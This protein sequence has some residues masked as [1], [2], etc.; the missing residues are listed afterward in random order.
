MGRSSFTTLRRSNSF[1]IQFFSTNYFCFLSGHILCFQP[2]N[3][4]RYR[5]LGRK[6]TGNGKLPKLRT[7]LKK[8]RVPA[9]RCTLCWALTAVYVVAQRQEYARS[10]NV[11]DDL[12][13]QC[14]AN[15]LLQESTF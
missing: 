5:R 10:E 1:D 12:P 2:P 11:V 6:R 3:G 7:N 4:W 15:M 14:L 9:V 13:N 8:R